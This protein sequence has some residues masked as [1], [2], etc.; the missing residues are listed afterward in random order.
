MFS[1]GVVLTFCVSVMINSRKVSVVI[2]TFSLVRS[3]STSIARISMFLYWRL[4]VVTAKGTL[5]FFRSSNC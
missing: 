4:P 2:N 5:L 1:A 3:V